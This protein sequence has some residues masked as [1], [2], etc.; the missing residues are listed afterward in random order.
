MACALSKIAPS[1]GYIDILDS[2]NIQTFYTAN[3][4]DSHPIR[5]I[6]DGHSSTT[7]ILNNI[8]PSDDSRLFN[9]HNWLQY[10]LKI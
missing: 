9:M 10:K 7:G 2:S 5:I 4:S 8:F 6:F 1:K 3:A